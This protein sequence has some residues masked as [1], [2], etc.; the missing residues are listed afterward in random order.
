LRE[1]ELMVV[2]SPRGGDEGF[3]A[4]LAQ[5][6]QVI[7]N[8]GG[9][10]VTTLTNPPWG[11]RKLAYAIQDF[12]DAYFAVLH[13][14]LEP[15]RVPALERDLQ[16]LE[17]V[18]RYLIVR[19]DEAIKAESKAASRRAAVTRPEAEEAEEVRNGVEGSE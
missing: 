12:R 8:H 17:Q 2:V 4:V 15:T 7:G 11:H 9:T 5:V 16:L 13:V 18:I 14:N 6:N 3:P 1:Y 10:V 19:R